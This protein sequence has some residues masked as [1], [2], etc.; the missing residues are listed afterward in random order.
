MKYE[1]KEQQQYA[2]MQVGD[3]QYAA[4]QEEKALPDRPAGKKKNPLIVAGSLVVAGAAIMAI[5]IAGASSSRYS[6][7]TAT[8]METT[9]VAEEYAPSGNAEIIDMSGITAVNIT[10]NAGEVEIV[11]GDS[12]SVENT[13]DVLQYNRSMTDGIM[14]IEYGINSDESFF[15]NDGG[16]LYITVPQMIVDNF[17]VTVNLGTASVSDLSCGTVKLNLNAG[18]LSVYN[19]K[20]DNASV[21]VNAGDAHLDGCTAEGFTSE[22]AAGDMIINDLLSVNLTV[23]STGGN[24]EMSNVNADK[25]NIGCKAGD[26]SYSGA[27]ESGADIN[28][29]MGDVELNLNRSPGEYSIKESGSKM[30]DITVNG[31]DLS[32][33]VRENPN[34]A[35]PITI[36]ANMSDVDING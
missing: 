8:T 2:E 20:A 25:L 16:M 33:F 32:D 7:D 3:F 1:E 19:L 29:S 14:S 13:S 9:Y 4:V 6:A 17:D 12:F 15:D 23:S 10:C 11:S 36:S 26:I 31:E 24:C 35:I 22:I 34:G 5:G 18:E 27:I 21:T 30:S 28:V